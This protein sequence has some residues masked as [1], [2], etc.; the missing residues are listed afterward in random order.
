VNTKP[1]KQAITLAA[2]G[3]IRSPFK[4]AAGMPIQPVFA[5]GTEG[6]VE[7]WPQY[8]EGLRDLEGFDE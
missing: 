2:I 3:I 7:V 6:T 5:E 1:E 8:A 4:E